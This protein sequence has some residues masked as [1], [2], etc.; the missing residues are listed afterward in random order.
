[1]SSP[2]LTVY[3]NGVNQVSGDQFNT[4]TQWCVNVAQLRNLVGVSNMLVYIQGFS[5]PNDGG[6]GNFYWNAG[7]TSPDD[8]GVT[9]VVPNGSASGCWSRLGFFGLNLSSLSVSGSTVLNN[10]TFS[11]TAGIIGVTNGSSADAGS[12]GEYINAFVSS[13]SAVSLTTAVSAN[14]TSIPLSPGD[15]DIG[16]K[17]GFVAGTGT[18]VTLMSGNIDTTSAATYN[19]DTAVTMAQISTLSTG[20]GLSFAIDT[21][22]VNITVASTYYLNCFA[23]F[24]T[25]TLKGY[26]GIWA[27]RIR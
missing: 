14:I 19:A 26:G 6:Q 15:W 1:M 23:G 9:T 13:A 3:Q 8:N 12:V 7:G 27:R 20:T 17:I 22:R 16:G 24:G 21:R 2:Q 10:L 11:S 18:T 25:S 4:F 5:V